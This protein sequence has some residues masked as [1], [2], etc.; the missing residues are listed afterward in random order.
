MEPLHILLENFSLKQAELLH[1]TLQFASDA[2]VVRDGRGTRVDSERSPIDPPSLS[3]VLEELWR[4][5]VKPILEALGYTVRCCLFRLI[6]TDL[7]HFQL[8]HPPQSFRSPYMVVPNR[9][10]RISSPPRSWDIWL[11]SPTRI[12]R[13]RFRGFVIYTDCWLSS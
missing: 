11:C 3:F 2:I 7:L 1:E 13:F 6:C 4:K 8:E 9:P 12:V 5:V 10:A